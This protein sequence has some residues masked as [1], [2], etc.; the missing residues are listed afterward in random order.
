MLTAVQKQNSNCLYAW[1]YLK[2]SD[3]QWCFHACTYKHTRI[4]TYILYIHRYE[5]MY[6]H[7]ERAIVFFAFVFTSYFSWFWVLIFILLPSTVVVARFLLFWPLV[8]YPLVASEE[9]SFCWKVDLLLLLLS[10][11]CVS[12]FTLT[13]NWILAAKFNLH[14]KHYNAR[15]AGV[16]RVRITSRRNMTFYISAFWHFSSTILRIALY[17]TLQA[18]AR[19]NW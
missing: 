5:Y 4:H 7:S 15:A 6:V 1:A 13:T 14:V 12:T 18:A 9:F 16:Y 3:R 11:C 2:A 17:C 8:T 10:L 19:G